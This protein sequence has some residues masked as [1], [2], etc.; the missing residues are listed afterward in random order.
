MI[1]KEKKKM[2]QIAI[3]IEVYNK[4]DRYCKKHDMPKSL[5]ISMI[6]SIFIGE[7]VKYGL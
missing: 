6:I 4:L 5:A 1:N 3:P 7:E 2:L